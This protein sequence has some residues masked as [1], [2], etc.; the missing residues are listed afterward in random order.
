MQPVTRK[1][2]PS[3]HDLVQS[4]THTLNKSITVHAIIRFRLHVLPEVIRKRSLIW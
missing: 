1:G 3:L 4:V 2:A